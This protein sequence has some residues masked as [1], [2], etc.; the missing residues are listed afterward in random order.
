M[1]TTGGRWLVVGAIAA[2]VSIAAG[3]LIE[4]FRTSVG[5][6]LAQWGEILEDWE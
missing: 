5:R 6:R 3:S 1:K 4:K 2:V